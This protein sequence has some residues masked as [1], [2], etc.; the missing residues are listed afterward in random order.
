M[1]CGAKDHSCPVRILTRCSAPPDESHFVTALGHSVDHY[2]LAPVQRPEDMHAQSMLAD[3]NSN[4]LE[5]FLRGIGSAVTFYL[6]F[7]R[8]TCM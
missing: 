7:E 3:V 4:T 2:L 1:L 8:I 6:L 5:C